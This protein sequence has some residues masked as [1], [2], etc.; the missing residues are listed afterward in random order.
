MILITTNTIIIPLTIKTVKL[1]TK[2]N[3]IHTQ[4]VS[5]NFLKGRLLGTTVF[6][7]AG[8]ELLSCPACTIRDYDEY[9]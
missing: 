6:L 8:E 5:R 1:D 4:K 9:D 2:K 7:G 3:L